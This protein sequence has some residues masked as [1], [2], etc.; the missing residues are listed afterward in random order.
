MSEAPEWLLSVSA[1]AKMTVH[2]LRLSVGA[3][4]ALISALR[5]FSLLSS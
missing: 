3:A 4:M 5:L 1:F 2:A